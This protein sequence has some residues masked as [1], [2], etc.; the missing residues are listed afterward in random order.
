M[1]AIYSVVALL[2]DVDK[3]WGNDLTEAD[4]YWYRFLTFLEAK[5]T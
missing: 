2:Y 5:R 1:F 3:L 4:G